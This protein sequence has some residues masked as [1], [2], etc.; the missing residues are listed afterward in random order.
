MKVMC[1]SSYIKLIFERDEAFYGRTVIIVGEPVADGFVVDAKSM[2]WYDNGNT[3][4]INKTDAIVI[5][6]KIAFYNQQHQL[7]KIILE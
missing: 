1:S 5:F 2:K 6:D 3:M 4:P 7:F